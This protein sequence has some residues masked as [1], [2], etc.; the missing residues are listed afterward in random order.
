MGPDRAFAALDLVNRFERLDSASVADAQQAMHVLHPRIRSLVPGHTI[1]GPA[2]TVRA[3]AGSMMTVQKA[4]VEAQPG[5]ILVVSADGDIRAGRL[6]G[7][8]MAAEAK[9]RAFK[10]IVIDGASRDSHDLR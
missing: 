7:G 1:C 9:R 10:G 5:D 6:W 8:I 2:F 3:Y 4:L